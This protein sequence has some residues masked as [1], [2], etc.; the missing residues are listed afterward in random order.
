V[1]G[2]TVEPQLDL[3]N[4][5]NANPVLAYNSTYGSAWQNPALILKGRLIKFG[6]QVKF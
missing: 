1:H 5:L 4:A 6:L 2:V 3:Y